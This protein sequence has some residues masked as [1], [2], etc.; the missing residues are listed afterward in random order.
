M[1]TRKHD[2]AQHGIQTLWSSRVVR[3]E[4]KWN[5]ME[6]DGKEKKKTKIK[7]W[8]DD[9]ILCTVHLRFLTLCCDVLRNVLFLFQS[10]WNFHQIR[11]NCD[12]S[13]IYKNEK[14]KEKN[15]TKERKKKWVPVT[16]GKYTKSFV[17]YLGSFIRN[18]FEVVIF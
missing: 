2:M 10:G 14:K 15:W 16:Y 13:E 18:K 4:M 1:R 17:P 6:L 9:V 12:E 11:D 7:E 8:K 5:E 3:K